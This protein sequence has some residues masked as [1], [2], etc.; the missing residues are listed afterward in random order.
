MKKPS[1]FPAKILLVIYGKDGY[2]HERFFPAP[3]LWEYKSQMENM[4]QRFGLKN[5][6]YKIFLISQSRINKLL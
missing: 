6:D 5:K 3:T 1:L 4:S 2:I